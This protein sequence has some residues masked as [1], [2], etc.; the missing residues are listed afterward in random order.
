MPK[1]QSA[2]KFRVANDKSITQWL[3]MFEAQCQALEIFEEQSKRN[4]RDILLV[5]TSDD[6]FATILAALNESNVIII[7]I[8]IIISNFYTG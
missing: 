2:E 4:W 6:A 3:S 1:I 5:T 7:I 8:I